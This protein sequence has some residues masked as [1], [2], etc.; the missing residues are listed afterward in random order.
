[1]SRLLILSFLIALA[2]CETIRYRM[3]PPP[4]DSGRLCVTQ[5]AGIRQM[6][7]GQEEQQANY[8]QHQCERRED[9]EYDHC[10]RK[11]GNDRDK[12]KKCERNRSYCS[13]TANTEGCEVDYRGC[14][15]SCGGM[16]IQ[17]V[18]KW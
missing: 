15:A 1:M 7:I 13:S 14:Y 8:E 3:V 11:A 10:M 9:H 5:C 4:S 17:E 16:V 12:V 2:G 18:E 6:C